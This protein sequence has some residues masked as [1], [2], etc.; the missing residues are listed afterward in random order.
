MPG[1]EGGERRPW[2]EVVY[3]GAMI[4]ILVFANWGRPQGDD[5]GIWSAI[6]T[7]KWYVS[8]AFALVLAVALV[9]WFTRDEMSEWVDNTW[10]FAKQILPLLFAGVLVAG[11]L[12]GS[13]EGGQ[14]IIPDAWVAKMVGGNSLWA[15]LFASVAGALMYFATL[16]EVPILEGLMR[17]GMGKGPALA[18]LLAGPALSLPNMLVIHSVLGTRKTGAFV[19]LVITLSTVAGLIYGAVL[20]G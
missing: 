6:F 19:A 16:T 2:Q 5:A 13:P 4:G 14:G 8:G 12:L 17:S 7:A 1:T 20:P 10:T 3:F 15:N 18:L 9:T 11:F